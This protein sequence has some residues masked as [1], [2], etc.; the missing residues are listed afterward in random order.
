MKKKN[1][2]FWWER[3]GG[4]HAP[5]SWGNYHT[6]ERKL[7]NWLAYFFF[8]NIFILLLNRWNKHLERER[9]RDNK[10]IEIERKIDREREIKQKVCKENWSYSLSSHPKIPLNAIL[11]I[12]SYL[13][14]LI[15]NSRA[16]LKLHC[17]ESLTLYRSG[18][19][20]CQRKQGKT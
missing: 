11:L 19:L 10:N 8:F 13:I 16:Q 9:E 5:R 15:L 4:Y 17:K 18:A 3:I 1:L 20:I 7:I 6:K 2:K 12:W 14:L